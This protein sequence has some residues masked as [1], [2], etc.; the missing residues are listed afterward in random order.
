ML[1]LSRRNTIV[2]FNGGSIK[3]SI[4]RGSPCMCVIP[5]CMGKTY[6]EVGV[7][8]TSMILRCIPTC[9]QVHSK[10]G[11]SQANEET[12]N[13]KAWDRKVTLDK[14]LQKVLSWEVK[15]YFTKKKYTLLSI[16]K[17]NSSYFLCIFC[18]C[19]FFLNIISYFL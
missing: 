19:I 6:R 15:K 3:E 4:I 11:P 1:S 13:G 14:S 7:F 16:Q 10:R 2:F 5:S 12:C 17:V 18:C 8:R 9:L